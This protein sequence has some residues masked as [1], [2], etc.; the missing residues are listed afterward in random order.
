MFLYSYLDSFNRC[1]ADLS[2]SAELTLKYS[3][4]R[5][6]VHV[7]L[8]QA[9]RLM[10]MRMIAIP[11]YSNSFPKHGSVLWALNG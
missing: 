7:N 6:R 10:A 8:I 11:I 2:I 9:D 5:K 4:L 3:W 1:S